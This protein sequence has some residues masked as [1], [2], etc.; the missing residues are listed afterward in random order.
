MSLDII[1]MG[2]V[3]NTCVL[4]RQRHQNTWFVASSWKSLILDKN[5]YS[6]TRPRINVLY[7]TPHDH[8]HNAILSAEINWPA[9]STCKH[10]KINILFRRFR[11]KIAK[12]DY[13][14]RH[15]CP[16]ERP[17]A[18]NNSAWKSIARRQVSLNFDKNNVK[19]YEHLWQY[20]A[21]VFL[22]WVTFQT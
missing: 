3:T 16:S 17:S 22:E 12:S 6:C 11:K 13:Q 2:C 8:R 21:E 5:S 15:V 9:S 7:P 4:L 1:H 19:T 18:W 10:S 14:L 20:F